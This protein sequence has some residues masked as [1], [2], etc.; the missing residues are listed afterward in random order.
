MGIN[1]CLFVTTKMSILGKSVDVG[2]NV[3][4]QFLIG[5]SFQLSDVEQGKP[6]SEIIF[7]FTRGAVKAS[8]L[9]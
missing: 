9:G 4:L 8:N 1:L 6:H 3:I 2:K 5:C 7:M